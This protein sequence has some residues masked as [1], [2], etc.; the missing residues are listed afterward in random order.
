MA[1]I[2]PVRGDAWWQRDLGV[3]PTAVGGDGT[4]LL[5][6][7]AD[8]RVLRLDPDGRVVTTSRVGDS[9]VVALVAG[10]PAAVLLADRLVGLDLTR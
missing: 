6:G 8:G 3:R 5:V 2:E 1:A 4:Q 10:R 7:T 9:S